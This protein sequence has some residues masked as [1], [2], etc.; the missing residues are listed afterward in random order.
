MVA[1]QG[2]FPASDLERYPLLIVY[3]QILRITTP[4]QLRWPLPFK[5]W[6][7]FYQKTISVESR[8]AT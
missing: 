2:W 5:S 1:W 7:D 6:Q 8:M 4:F 3:A